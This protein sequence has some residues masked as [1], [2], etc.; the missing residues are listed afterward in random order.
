M[1]LTKIKT[2]SV[3][4]SITLTT[5]DIN[6][7]DID[8]GTIDGTTV[9][10]SSAST[11]AFTT[12]S[13][14]G[15]VTASGNLNFMGGTNDA[16]YIKFGDSGDDDIGNILYYHGNNNMV[17]TTNASEAIR[18]NASGNVGI[19][20][21]SP[22]AITNYTTVAVNGT[23]GGILDFENGEVLNSRLIGE[24]GGLL[25]SGEG[26]RY[27]KFHTNSAERMRI[28]SSGRVTMPYQPAFLTQLAG[29]QANIAVA[30]TLTVLFATER[31]DQGSNFANNTFTAP[32]TGRYQLNVHVLME[33]VDSA[34]HYYQIQL[35]TSNRLYYDTFD[36]RTMSTD[37]SYET[38][39]SV[40]L[41]D[42]DAG[43][44]AIVK[45]YQS[46]GTAQTNLNAT[47]STFSGY[48]VA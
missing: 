15:T 32:V 9:G 41:A 28:D 5:P 29:T 42:M 11:G 48:L 3:S 25:L 30:T 39:K 47:T 8:G 21:A 12:L 14:S 18:I 36:P 10:A 46:T 6:T 23:T 26:S 27:I 38:L 4:D 35:T 1:A 44:T 2:G 33:N 31:F 34:S 40:V 20:T 24:A 16:Q 45:I 37:S 22:T 13:A 17:F 43:D 7:P 19:G